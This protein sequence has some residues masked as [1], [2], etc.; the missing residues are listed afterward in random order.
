MPTRTL[1]QVLTF[2]LI[3]AFLTSMLLDLYEAVK[4]GGDYEDMTE[5]RRRTWKRFLVCLVIFLVFFVINI[6]INR[7]RGSR[8][9]LFTITPS[10]HF[11]GWW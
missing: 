3:A 2:L 11:L 7:N 8:S 1:L 9:L 5:G 6:L 10:F 4:V